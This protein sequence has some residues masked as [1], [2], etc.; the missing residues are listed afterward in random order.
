MISEITALMNAGQGL[1]TIARTIHPY[2]TQA[3]VIKKVAIAWR[4]A[5]FSK[6]QKKVLRKWFQWTR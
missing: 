3:E 5:K 1:G 2:P 6:R 4:K